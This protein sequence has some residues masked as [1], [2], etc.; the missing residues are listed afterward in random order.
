M[1][2]IT[3]LLLA[4]INITVSHA[5][6]TFGFLYNQVSNQTKVATVFKN[7]PAEKAGLQKGD[8]I[9]VVNSKSLTDLSL[10]DVTKLFIEASDNSTISY[11]RNQTAFNNVK[12]S[13]AP[14]ENFLNVCLSGNC[15]DG[16]GEFVDD[17]GQQYKGSFVKGRRSDNG[18]VIYVNGAEYTGN[19]EN[20]VKQ[21]KGKDVLVNGDTYEG[22]FANGE[23]N[24]AG[25]FTSISG[26]T[27]SGTFLSGK[28]DG[29]IIHKSKAGSS[30]EIYKS[31]KLI[32]T[33][34]IEKSAATSSDNC[35]S[36]NCINGFGK[37]IYDNFGAY[38]GDFVDGNRQGHGTFTYKDL[39]VYT[40]QFSNNSLSGKGKFIYYN[41]DIYEGNYVN[42]NNQGQGTFTLAN[43]DYY[44]GNWN[45][46]VRDG[47]GK[48]YNKG[49][50]K[51]W[52]GNWKDGVFVSSTAPAVTPAGSN[53]CI[54]GNCSNG[55]GKYI[56]SKGEIYEGNFVYK[57]PEGQGTITY[58]N[59]QVH[60]GQ[61]S[62]G[63]RNGL[64]KTTYPDGDFYEGNWI[65]S[66]KEGQGTYKY[67]DG[68]VYTGQF[69]NN[70]Y[71]G[72]GKIV[73]A[74]GDTYEGNF[75]N[76]LRE[77]KGTYKKADGSYYT[78]E[79][80]KDKQD[81]YGKSY[82]KATGKTR[83]GNWKQDTFVSGNDTKPQTTDEKIAELT[84]K[85]AKTPNNVDLY[86]S[87]GQLYYN[88]FD[89]ELALSD[90]DKALQITP[91]N[92]AAEFLKDDV[93]YYLKME[94]NKKADKEWAKIGDDFNT[95]MVDALDKKKDEALALKIYDDF[96]KTTVGWRYD[97]NVKNIYKQLLRTMYLKGGSNLTGFILKQMDS[98]K[99]S[100]EER[101]GVMASRIVI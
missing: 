38:E 97:P 50:N 37:F 45:N 13:R 27:Y 32:S 67:K 30:T 20:G 35:V 44:I 76:G 25:I 18:R 96:D 65:K 40:G 70:K 51:V 75:V 63:F 42:G 52:E 91:G 33:T 36:G 92:A 69:A 79:W 22:N 66:V 16:E 53:K 46:G 6:K 56:F 73:Y 21:G 10:D 84:K 12:I 1:K 47:L 43:G 93:E 88:S 17:R 19:W 15:Q 100:R 34:A 64:G 28:F 83:E 9:T 49:T 59:G 95:R 26:D 78:G 77:G 85:I 31:G 68:D 3:L 61:F 99:F 41:G 8:I 29:T 72:K 55:Y 4:F 71:N 90:A 24:G 101:D 14:S 89:Y 39:G 5:Q 7:S 86:I 74:D 60:T 62:K 98:L 2:L 82:D 48:Q 94:K 54:S 87:R 58:A 81:G 80:K 11:T 23:Y 57:Q